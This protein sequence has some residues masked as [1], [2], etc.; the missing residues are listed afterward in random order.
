MNTNEILIN[1][2]KFLINELSSIQELYFDTL[3]DELGI[4]TDYMA[5]VADYIFSDKGMTLE[6]FLKHSGMT[7]DELYEPAD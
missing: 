2:T 3:C 6:E 5:I 4:K 7:E 1:K